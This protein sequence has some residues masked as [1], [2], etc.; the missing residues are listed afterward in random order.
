M[1]SAGILLMSIPRRILKL[2]VYPPTP[3]K[4]RKNFVSVDSAGVREN[5]RH[6]KGPFASE[7]STEML[8]LVPVQERGVGSIRFRDYGQILDFEEIVEADYLMG[9]K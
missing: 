2:W 5:L 8:Q 6:R 4:F 9:A 7:F 3:P 1:A